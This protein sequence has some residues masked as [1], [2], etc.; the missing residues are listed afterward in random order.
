MSN[1][2]PRPAATVVLLREASQGI[3]VL[4][5]QRS[6]ELAFS[7]GCWVFPGGKIDPQ[8]Y[9]DPD[10]THEYPAA[11]R[12]AVRETREEAG[13]S[14]EP[15]QLIPAAHWT[16]PESLPLRYSTWFFLCP[17]YQPV[18]V[19]IDDWEIR[20]YRW[21]SPA[22]ALAESKRRTL[23]LIQPTRITLQ[24][25]RTYLTLEDAL[26]GMTG[27]GIRVV[28]ENSPYYRPITADR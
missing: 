15:E 24:D 18:A 25:L 22:R 9:P 27:K 17:L 10:G 4:L 14:I 23:K 12:A 2:E 20:D 13:I 19:T 26:A 8:D 5:L 1:V 3:E 7:P 28:P 21:I 16:T 6:R 11:L